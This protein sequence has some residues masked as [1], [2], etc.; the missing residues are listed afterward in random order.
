VEELRVFGIRIIYTM[1]YDRDFEGQVPLE[2]DM[3]LPRLSL[4]HLSENKGKGLSAEYGTEVSKAKSAQFS[5]LE[6][7]E[8]NI[9]ESGSGELIKQIKELR[10]EIYEMNQRVLETEDD[11]KVK[12]SETEEL[13]ELLIQLKNDHGTILETCEHEPSCKGCYTF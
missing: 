13:K 7:C 11:L 9:R 10:N 6:G 3:Q 4:G 2:P 8:R 5:E 1:N 12:D